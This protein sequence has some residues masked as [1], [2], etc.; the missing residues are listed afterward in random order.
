RG[1]TGVVVMRDV[2]VIGGGC[3]GTFYAGQLAKAKQR[4]R[5]D[6]RRVVVVDRDPAC[7]ARA[8]LGEAPDRRF[9]T[10]DWRAYF[11]GSL[12]G[13]AGVRPSAVR[14]SAPRLRRRDL[15]GRGR[16]GGGRHRPDGGAERRAGRGARGH[17]EFVSRR[18]ELAEARCHQPSAV[19]VC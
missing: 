19:S 10:R 3:Y 2:S 16:A 13:R 1:L 6:Y 5:A 9:V 17:G 7:R 14:V 4:G 12:A 18:A 8:E 15:L 11:A